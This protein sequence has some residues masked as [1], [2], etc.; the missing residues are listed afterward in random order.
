MYFPLSC[1]LGSNLTSRTNYSARSRQIEHSLHLAFYPNYISRKKSFFHKTNIGSPFLA[2]SR[3]A[4]FFLFFSKV[5]FRLHRFPM[6]SVVIFT[7]T[8][9]LTPCKSSRQSLPCNKTP[10]PIQGMIT[11]H[12]ALIRHRVARL[13]L[14]LPN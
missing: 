7:A 12:S 14:S 8:T 5:P 11:H 9:T 10:R 2:Q 4:F 3:R 13:N 1:G 6:K